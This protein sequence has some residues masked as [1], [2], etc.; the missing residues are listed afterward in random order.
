M[1]L[2]ERE[3]QILKQLNHPQIPKCK[4]YFSLDDRTLWFGL[5][6][7]YI[8]G[9]SLKQKLNEGATFAQEQIEQI[10]EDILKI[11]LFCIN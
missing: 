5:V 11:L 6:Q 1:K 9:A 3:A 7:E 10:A 8:P 2:F 4:D